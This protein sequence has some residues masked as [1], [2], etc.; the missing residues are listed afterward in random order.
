MKSLTANKAL[1]LTRL[2]LRFSRASELRRYARIAMKLIVI[3]EHKS[4][5]PN[6]IRFKKGECLVTGEKDTEFEGWIWVTTNDG[7]QG[8]A[9]MQYL[10]LEE[11]T[12]QAIAKQDYTAEELDT[13]VGEELIL[14]YEVSDWGWVEKKDGTSGWVPMKTTRI[15]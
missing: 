6:P 13:F 1:H 15:A 5:Y 11:G 2:P 9:P 3:E 14:R 7:N 4:D 10:Q 8:W 12:N